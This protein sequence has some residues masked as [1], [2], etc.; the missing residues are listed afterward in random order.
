MNL[1]AKRKIQISVIAFIF[2]LVLVALFIF[3]PFLVKIKDNGEILSAQKASLLFLEKQIKNV[4]DFQKQFLADNGDLKNL[5][6]SFLNYAAPI[7][8]FEFLEQEALD[9]NVLL[10]VSPLLDKPQDKDQKEKTK[11]KTMIFEVVIAGDFPDCLRFLKQIERGPF[12]SQVT[13]VSIEK[14]DKNTDKFKQFE[15]LLP[16]QV[17]SNVHLEVLAKEKNVE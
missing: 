11:I 12:L 7:E 4:Q 6:S 5:D 16:G 15:G 2:V 3:R 17:I 14:L 9:A 13:G 10:D 1:S 8:F